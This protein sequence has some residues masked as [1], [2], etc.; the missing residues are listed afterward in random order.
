[1]TQ[2]LQPDDR[3]LILQP[4]RHGS[5]R[6][7]EWSRAL[8]QGLLVGVGEQSVIRNAR[9]ELADCENALFASG[10]RA[11]IPWRDGF[12]TVIVDVETGP[13]TPDMLRVLHPAGRIYSIEP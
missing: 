1:M 10:S 6:L 9:R 8:P 7:R 3:V 4:E 13:A 12:F 2:A 11:E 5:L